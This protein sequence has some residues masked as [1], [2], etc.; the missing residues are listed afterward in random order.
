MKPELR[1][2][3]ELIPSVYNPRLTDPERLNLLALSIRKLGWLSPTYATRSNE[4]LSG[5]QRSLVARMLGYS[6]VP[7]VTVDDLPE[8]KRRALNLVFNRATNDMEQAADTKAMKRELLMKDLNELTASL[9]DRTEHY[10]CMNAVSEPIAP[11][12][13]INRHRLSHYACTIARRLYND[14]GITM[15]I[16]VNEDGVVINGIGRLELLASHEKTHGTFVKISNAEARFADVCLNLISMDFD[17][18]VKYADFLRFNAFRRGVTEVKANEDGT[19]CLGWGFP[20]RMG[21]IARADFNIY[22]PYHRAL[23]KKTYGASVVDFGGGRGG[24]TLALRA[25]GIRVSFF[26]PYFCT[27]G[28]VVNIEAS[29]IVAKTFIEDVASGVRYSSVF[30][31]AVINSIPFMEDRRKVIT[32]CAALCSPVTVMYCIAHGVRNSRLEGLK[33]SS[34]SIADKSTT[35]FLDYEPNVT[36]GEL[37]RSPK[38]QKFHTVEELRD[39]FS[40]FKNVSISEI[41]GGEFAVMANQPTI[42]PAKLRE[43]IEFEFD[44]PYSDGSRMGL[45]AE[46]KAAFSKRLK[47]SL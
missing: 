12:L 40:M 27:D 9:P 39:L 43:A 19:G 29:K 32:I 33:A 1:S 21:E 20:F 30:L 11:Y 28:D 38:V 10:P 25:N 13:E 23:W 5:H 4:L 44:L 45:V 2:I 34:V 37:T 41:H 35:F 42:D 18:G 16:I 46:A 3:E 7:C 47:I 36:V 22:K 17:V 31:S 6:H 24:E 8:T 14:F 15:P 26:E